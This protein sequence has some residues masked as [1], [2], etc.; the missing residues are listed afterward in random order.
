MKRA[1]CYMSSYLKQLTTKRIGS[2]V[3]EDW[4]S[5]ALLEYFISE[6]YTDT[7]GT[8]YI[9]CNEYKEQF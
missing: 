5:V 4:K 1:L 9:N 8:Q 2:V 7:S 3:S 6:W